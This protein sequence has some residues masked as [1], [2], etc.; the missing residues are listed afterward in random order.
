TN[1]AQH[2][3]KI[4][5]GHALLLVHSGPHEFS[6]IVRRVC[7]TL[8]SQASRLIGCQLDETTAASRRRQYL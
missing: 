1:Q 4:S 2:P 6:S 8:A 7:H 3:T 5:A